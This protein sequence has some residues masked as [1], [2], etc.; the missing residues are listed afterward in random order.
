MDRLLGLDGLLH[1]S[2]K[3]DTPCSIEVFAAGNLLKTLGLA[4]I[5]LGESGRF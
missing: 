5:M 4:E 2:R 1:N 3:V